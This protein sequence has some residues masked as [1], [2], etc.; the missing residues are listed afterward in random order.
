MSRR[1]IRDAEIVRQDIQDRVAV[2]QVGDCEGTSEAE[3][4]V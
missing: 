1:L 3:Q 2:V 4:N